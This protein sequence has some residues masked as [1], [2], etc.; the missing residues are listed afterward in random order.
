MAG[1]AARHS[2][3]W[4]GL[5]SFIGVAVVAAETHRWMMW[6]QTLT[7]APHLAR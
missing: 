4:L 3:T 5:A 2:A 6:G 7:E 1:A